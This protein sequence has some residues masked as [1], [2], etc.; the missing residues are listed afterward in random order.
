[1]WNGLF[2]VINIINCCF[3]LHK[4]RPISLNPIEEE[5]YVK[6]F[7][8]KKVPLSRGDFKLLC[9]KA[10]ILDYED[11]EAYLQ[12]NAVPETVGVIMSGCM[13]VFGGFVA[14]GTSFKINANHPWEWVDSP[15][16]ILNTS[17]F[18]ADRRPSNVALVSK[19]STTLCIW[20]FEDI[21]ALCQA[22]PQLA[23]CLTTVISQDCASKIIQTEHYLL[24]QDTIRQAAI[25]ALDETDRARR[26]ASV[27][28]PAPTPKQ[29][30]MVG[31][32]GVAI[33]LS[34]STASADIRPSPAPPR[35]LG[36]SIARKPSKTQVSASP[37][38]KRASPA[39][40]AEVEM[41]DKP[42]KKKKAPQKTPEF[43]SASA[44]TVPNTQ[45][46][47]SIVPHTSKSSKSG[48]TSSDSEEEQAAETAIHDDSSESSEMQSS[49]S[50]PAKTKSKSKKTTRKPAKRKEEDSES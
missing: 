26:E 30:I 29:R 46:Q 31:S 4:E 17:E 36:E 24:T 32:Q 48:T 28:A 40:G 25:A 19:G 6:V 22:N 7:L 44:G 12:Y 35:K 21:R 8:K 9:S 14:D 13:D 11:G 39:T 5:L 20:T 1:M 10:N 50:E 38:T 47:P 33:D 41:V 15:Q 2:A 23:V 27:I 18:P 49:D 43:S 16:F 45:A 42:K 3:L 34:D 37:S